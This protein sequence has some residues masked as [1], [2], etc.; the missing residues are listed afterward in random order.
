MKAGVARVDVGFPNNRETTGLAWVANSTIDTD[1]AGSSW[2]KRSH[3]LPRNVRISIVALDAAIVPKHNYDT[4]RD[5][6]RV[7][8]GGA[9]TRMTEKHYAHL[10]PSYVAQTIRANFPVLRLSDG[11]DV[12]PTRRANKA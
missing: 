5:C 12:I 4:T 9:N 1:P 6:E 2:P 8:Y 3:S 7:F 10:A 11:A